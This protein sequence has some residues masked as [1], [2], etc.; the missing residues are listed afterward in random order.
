LLVE[1]SDDRVLIQN[2]ERKLISVATAD[3][4]QILLTRTSLM[5]E[6]TLSDLTAQEAADLLEFLLGN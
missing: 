5:P 4:D 6:K 1:Q 2:A 3:I